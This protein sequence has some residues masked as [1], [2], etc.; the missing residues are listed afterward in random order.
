MIFNRGGSR[1]FS[2]GADS[3]KV[4]KIDFPRSPK[5]LKRRFFSQIFAPVANF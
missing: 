2:R 4:D 1:I 5:A 3:Q